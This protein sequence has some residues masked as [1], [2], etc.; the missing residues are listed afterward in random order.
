MMQHMGFSQRFTHIPGFI[1]ASDSMVMLFDLIER[2]AK[3]PATVLIEGESGTGKELIA[4][5][6]HCLSERASQPFIRFNSAALSETLIESEL[7]GHEPG[8]FTGAS[9]LRKGRFELADGGSIFI[10]EIGELSLN[11][12]VKLLRILQEK[13]F[14]RVGGSTT[15]KTNVRVIASTNKSLHKK[16]QLG[17]F[18]DDLFYRLNMFPVFVPPLRVRD[19]DIELIAMFFLKSYCEEF[20]KSISG[21]SEAALHKLKTYHWPGNVRELQNVMSRAVIMCDTHQLEEE[22]IFFHQEEKRIYTFS[23][24]FHEQWIEEEELVKRYAQYI[25]EKCEHNKKKT[26]EILGINFRT[27]LSRLY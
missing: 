27:L 22:D 6:L 25:F 12:Q 19:G 13:E 2:V 20:H 11:M 8:A 4:K 24:L 26:A 15:I 3:T 10:D 16:V 18:R 9:S 23:D 21:F 7:F 14:E 17:E 5:A 1:G